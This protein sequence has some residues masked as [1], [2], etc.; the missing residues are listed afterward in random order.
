MDD[1][2]ALGALAPPEPVEP[3][4]PRLN[5]GID[6]QYTRILPKDQQI[7]MRTTVF[8]DEPESVVD[9]LLD[10]IG[11]HVNRQAARSS[12]DQLEQEWMQVGTTLTGI[13]VGLPIAEK[14]H[15]AA[16]E[17]LKAQIEEASTKINALY[18]EGKER[19]I[20]SGRQGEYQPQGNIAFNMDRIAKG[21]KKIEDDIKKLKAERRQELQSALNSIA[22]YRADMQARTEKINDLRHAVG[23]EP[24]KGFEDVMT[25]K[26]PEL[27]PVEE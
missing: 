23:R 13:T 17:K 14:N 21:A 11:E 1:H 8:A 24:I 19:W 2:R 20:N 3:P 7:V 9:A 12:L 5:R 26:L 27:G 18:E 15:L 16:L 6:I 22:H 4:D 25:A 10:R